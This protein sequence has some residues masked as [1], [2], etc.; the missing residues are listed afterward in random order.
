FVRSN[1]NVLGQIRSTIKNISRFWSINHCKD[2]IEKIIDTN[3]L[4]LKTKQE[5]QISFE[6][7]V[8]DAF[9]NAFNSKLFAN[10]LYDRTT[11]K[12]SNEEWEFA[13]VEGLKSIFPDPVVI[14]RTGGPQEIEHGTDI[15]IRLPGLLGF[16][17]LIAIQV[18]D[19][20]GIVGN[21][22]I[23]QI[24]KADSYWSNE[25][26]KLIDKYLII[27]KANKEDNAKLIDNRKD[28][29]II[30]A[31]ELKELLATIGKSYLGLSGN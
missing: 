13:L 18:K 8:T 15:L 4:D 20:S 26:S 28:V 23:S 24:Q 11:T 31:N 1:E 27:T 30:F 2:D 16:Q 21:D 10:S 14:E 29:K 25:N 9:E 22:P 5:L 19:Y 17:Y 7:N 6:K 3:N 12:F